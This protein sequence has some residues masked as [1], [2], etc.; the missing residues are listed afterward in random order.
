[1]IDQYNHRYGSYEGLGSGERSHM[2]PEISIE[3]MQDANYKTR[4]CYYVPQSEVYSRL[5]KIAQDS[6]LVGFRAI[7]SAGL[8][9]SIT[10]SYLPISGTSN[11]LPLVFFDAQCVLLAPSFVACMNSF[12]LDFIAKQKIAGSNLNFFILRQLAVLPPRVFLNKCS[13]SSSESNNEWIV[14]RVIELTCTSTDMSDLAT[15]YGVSESPFFW[16][17]ERRF[18]LRC[19]LDAAYFHLYLGNL[20]DWQNGPEELI[21]LFPTPRNAVDYIM[22]TFTIVKSIDEEKYEGDY[23]TKRVILEI[24]DAMQE[25]IRTGQPYQTL[26]DPPPA[27][28][29]CCHPP[30]RKETSPT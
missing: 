10:F 21:R 3:R 14:K 9:R 13:W 17:E 24:Y 1:M 29:R 28:P 5:G 19:E 16:D 26:L 2:L 15:Q 20:R 27:D 22:D 8:A 18:L 11:S 6:W 12:I 30:K 4:S 25:S 7:A 23:R